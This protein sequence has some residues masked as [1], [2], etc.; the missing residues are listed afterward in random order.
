M[1]AER[2]IL[3]MAGYYVMVPMDKYVWVLPIEAHMGCF[4]TFPI[5]MNF[6][7]ILYMALTVNTLL[8]CSP[9][10]NFCKYNWSVTLVISVTFS[11]RKKNAKIF[12]RGAVAVYITSRNAYNS[13]FYVLTSI[14]YGQG[15]CFCF[16]QGLISVQANLELTMYSRLTS[17]SWQYSCLVFS[18]LRIIGMSYHT[19]LFGI[20]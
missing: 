2:P 1:Y 5:W 4:Y 12:A 6:I 14:W 9:K 18:R 11:F 8:D 7:P 17:N 19:Q 10:D 16:W 13:D 3:F 20:P 15:S